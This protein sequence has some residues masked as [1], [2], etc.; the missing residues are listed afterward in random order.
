MPCA[1]GRG[2]NI[3]QSDKA[4]AGRQVSVPPPLSPSNTQVSVTPHPTPHSASRGQNI[5]QSQERC[6][7]KTRVCN[8]P[9]HTHTVHVEGKIFISS[10]QKQ[11][12]RCMYLPPPPP[13]PPPTICP[14]GS[15][16][17]TFVSWALVP[18]PHHVE[19]KMATSSTGESL[20][21]TPP[22]PRCT[23]GR[24]QMQT[25]NPFYLQIFVLTF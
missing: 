6:N 11:E 15:N 4:A 8:I 2:Q 13:P 5:H 3:H 14:T 21:P 23:E 20:P 10:T 22:P 9:P 24:G 12:D 1:P 17:K 7:R 25:G 19:G 18:S 16:M